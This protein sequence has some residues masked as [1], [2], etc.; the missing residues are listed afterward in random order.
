MNDM[1]RMPD[2]P[3]WWKDKDI[4]PEQ[5]LQYFD[6]Y[7]AGWTYD[8]EPDSKKAHAELTSGKCSNGYFN[9]RDLFS[10][11]PR[12]CA[13][14]SGQLVKKIKERRLVG[15][16]NWVIGSSYSAITASYEVAKI[17]GASHGFTETEKDPTDH[18]KK[19]QIWT[20]NIPAGSRILQVED[21]ITTLGTS[22]QVREAVLKNNEEQPIE[23]LPYVAVIVHR[24]AK[25]PIDYGDKWEIIPLLEKEV[26]AVDPPCDLCNAGSK[27]LRP[28]THWKELTGKA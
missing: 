10:K 12:I 4:T 26:W 24:P 11:N 27:R 8:G 17:L 20:G 23:F 18:K 1:L 6:L 25:L 14:F 21:L 3:E 7:E 13:I 28:K 5:V 9:C 19:K 22:M 2:D 16:F 15:S